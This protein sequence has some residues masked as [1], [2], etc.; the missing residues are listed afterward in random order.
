[1]CS[2]TL[3]L[4]ATGCC[5]CQSLHEFKKQLE[6]F[7]GGKKD[8][9]M[10]INHKDIT[11][12]LGNLGTPDCGLLWERNRQVLLYA[13]AVPMPAHCQGQ[14]PGIHQPQVYLPVQAFLYSDCILGHFWSQFSQFSY[15]Y[16]LLPLFAPYDPFSQKDSN[17][18]ASL[19]PQT[20]ELFNGTSIMTILTLRSTFMLHLKHIFE[21]KATFST[22][23]ESITCFKDLFT[24]CKICRIKLEIWTVRSSKIQSINVI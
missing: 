8:P 12:G 21:E 4:I 7:T 9:W 1:M 20:L 2:W 5:R 24:L 22:L 15:S 17:P 6:K 11:S 10:P 3:E 18:R 19:F 14:D 23:K 13:Y 16:S